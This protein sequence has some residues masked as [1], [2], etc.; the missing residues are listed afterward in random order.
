MNPPSCGFTSLPI[1]SASCFSRS[2]CSFDRLFGVTTFA[3]DIS[4][5]WF[6]VGG[7]ISAALTERSKLYA[8]GEYNFGAVN[9]WGATA[10][11]KIGW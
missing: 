11:V 1:D 6:N 4:G 7:G 8:S 9:G 10:G 5:T 2:F 3:Q